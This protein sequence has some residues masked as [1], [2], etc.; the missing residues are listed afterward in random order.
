MILHRLHNRM[1]LLNWSDPSDIREGVGFVNAQL[2]VLENTFAGKRK[3]EIIV[4]P[5]ALYRE[6]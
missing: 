1:E 3:N 4:D 6:M 2:H 5:I